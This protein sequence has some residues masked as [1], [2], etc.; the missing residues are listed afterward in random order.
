MDQISNACAGCGQAA[1]I[2]ILETYVAG[3]PVIRHFCF[4]CA[5]RHFGVPEPGPPVHRASVGSL[6]IVAGLAVG[7]LGLAGRDGFGWKQQI[8]I[9]LGLLFI[10]IGIVVRRVRWRTAARTGASS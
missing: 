2:R 8:A 4:E 10:T 5:D 9:G 7:L 1:R 3:R 6:L